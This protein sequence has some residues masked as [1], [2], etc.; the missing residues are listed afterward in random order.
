MLKKLFSPILIISLLLTTM[1]VVFSAQVVHYS[2][3][4]GSLTF[5]KAQGT[6][7]GFTGSPSAIIIPDEIEGVIVTGIG[8]GAFQNYAELQT[9][10]LPHHLGWIGFS[11]FEDCENL[12]AVTM[13]DGL[14]WI[15]SDAF[16]GCASLS[17]CIIPNSVT[18]IGDRAFFGCTALSSLSISDNIISIGEYTFAGCSALSSVYISANVISIN[19][20]AFDGHSPT[21]VIKGFDGS[22]SLSRSYR[23]ALCPGIC[24]SVRCLV[25]GTRPDAYRP[26]DGGTDAGKPD[27]CFRRGNAFIPFIPVPRHRYAG[28]PA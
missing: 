27:P 14:R 7:V 21:L 18:W 13:P 28:R 22:V 1:P 19:V 15:G 26:Y 11:A 2:I 25:R 5:D 10:T 24:R 17:A 16:S 23:R 4:G 3:P 6:I 12:I 20:T 8:T 9:I